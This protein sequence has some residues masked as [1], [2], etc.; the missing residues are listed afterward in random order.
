MANG[1]FY[2]MCFQDFFLSIFSFPDR[3]ASRPIMGSIIASVSYDSPNFAG[4]RRAGEVISLFVNT[5]G[6]HKRCFSN[7]S[8]W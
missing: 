8:L 4:G 7:A 2:R 1:V 6:Q 5:E 3:R